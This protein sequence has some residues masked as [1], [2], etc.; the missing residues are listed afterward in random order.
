[1][2]RSVKFDYRAAIEDSLTAHPDGLPLDDLLSRSGFNVDRTTLFRH[3]TRLI[4][5]G[6]VERIG[7]ARASRYRLHEIAP[8]RTEL[9]APDTQRAEPDRVPIAAPDYGAAVKKAVRTIVREWKRCNRVNLEIYL[10]LLVPSEHLNDVAAAVERELIGLHE[11]NLDEFGLSP[12][13]FSNFVPPASR[14]ASDE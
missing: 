5:A 14:D 12:A 1:M 9:T 4:E 10:S 8:V 3:L 6:R 13:D 2:G 11:G 7:N